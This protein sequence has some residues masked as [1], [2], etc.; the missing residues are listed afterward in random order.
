M[1]DLRYVMGI[2]GGGSKTDAVLM[3]ETGAVVGWGRGGPTHAGFEPD[4]AVRAA[5]PSAVAAALNGRLIRVSAIVTSFCGPQAIAAAHELSAGADVHPVGETD[6]VFA[7]NQ[8]DAGLIVLASTGSGVRARNRQGESVHMGGFGPVIGDEG[9]AYAIGVRAIRACI[10]AH[11][12]S[13]W[14]TSLRERVLEATHCARVYDLIGYFHYGGSTRRE[15]AALA[16]LVDQES[17]AGDPVAGRI[18]AESARELGVLALCALRRANMLDASYP[19]LPSGS[20]AR[21]SAAY[22]KAMTEFVCASA[23]LI[24]PQAPGPAPAVGGALLALRRLGVEWTGDVV[25][26]ARTTALEW[27]QPSGH[28]GTHTPQAGVW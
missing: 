26:R 22:W 17:A 11:W 9:S 5:V 28:S 3:D 14:D 7:A 19:M 25:T 2:D 16:P 12:S 13:E 6:V 20:V 1:S 27:S 23:P 24:E 10:Y 4:E 21:N 8:V 18:L 15:V